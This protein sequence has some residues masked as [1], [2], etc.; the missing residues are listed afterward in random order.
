MKQR[1]HRITLIC[2]NYEYRTL[3]N[4]VSNIIT[5]V[6]TLKEVRYDIGP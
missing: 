4:V 3:H 5:A 6:C 2:A 1:E